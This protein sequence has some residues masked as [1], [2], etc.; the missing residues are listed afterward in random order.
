MSPYEPVKAFLEQLGFPMKGQ[1]FGG[2]IVGVRSGEPPM[3]VINELKMP[4]TLELLLQGVG[5]LRAADEV[6]LAVLATRRG[7]DRDRRAHRLCRLL[8]FGPLA[9][10]PA[11][12]TVEILAEPTP[13]RPRPNL[14]QRRRLLKEHATRRGV[15]TRGG[16][17]RQPTMTAYR[18]QAIVCA[19]SQEAGPMRRPELTVAPGAGPI[20]DAMSIAGS[21]T[22]SPASA[23]SATQGPRRRGTGG[24]VRTRARPGPGWQRTAIDLSDREAPIPLRSGGSAACCRRGRQTL[25]PSH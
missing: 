19:T 22:C 13:S 21:S 10:H 20:L 6:W 2:D 16:S 25:K 4:L 23:S 14:P 24:A 9:V 18:Q 7:R 11:D 8:G 1:V 15:T 17:S 5:R 3:V 12:G